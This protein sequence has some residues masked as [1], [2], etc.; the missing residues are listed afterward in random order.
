MI[1]FSFVYMAEKGMPHKISFT[2][3]KLIMFQIQ[4]LVVVISTKIYGLNIYKCRCKEKNLWH[5]DNGL[6]V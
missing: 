4:A 6:G 1:H 3:S 5:I 2:D